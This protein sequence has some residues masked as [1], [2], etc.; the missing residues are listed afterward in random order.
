MENWM[1]IT[2]ELLINKFEESKREKKELYHQ[3]QQ[4]TQT[5]EKSIVYFGCGVQGN[6][7]YHLLK[8]KNILP[9]FYCD[10]NPELHGKKVV[11]DKICISVEELQ[12]MKDVVVLLTVGL[13]SANII[14]EQLIRLGI[15]EILKFPLDSLNIVTDDIFDL[16]QEEIE[17]NMNK[18]YAILQDEMSCRIAYTKLY[19]MLAST[20][21]MNKFNYIDIYSEPQ[22]YPA[23][24]ISLKKGECIVEG[25]SY[26]G[27]SLQYFIEDMKCI[28]FEKYICYELDEGNYNVLS[29]YVKTLDSNLRE[30][31]V[32]RNCGIA[33]C[34]KTIQYESI[35][36]GSNLRNDIV[37][38]NAKVAQIVALDSELLDEKVTFIKMDIEGSEIDALIGCKKIITKQRPTLA[39]CVYHKACHLWEVP[40]LIHDYNSNYKLYLR[41]HTLITTDTVCYAL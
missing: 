6:V 12:K 16:S 32:L 13:G 36:E 8:K 17:R 4:Y 3:L 21:E 25:G 1:K 27:D 22:Y 38:D 24:I 15:T 7:I 10:N 14:Y 23:D 9:K 40:F 19:C 26:I 30:R 2:K 29:N 5:G 34:N 31:I 39:I 37:T 41:H 18:L 35:E 11:E 28:D 33:D 20:K